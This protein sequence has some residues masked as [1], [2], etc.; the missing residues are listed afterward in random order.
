MRQI[1]LL[2][3]LG[4]LCACRSR[5]GLA[6]FERVLSPPDV[7]AALDAPDPLIVLRTQGCFGGYFA[8]VYYIEGDTLKC[9]GAEIAWYDRPDG[10]QLQGCGIAWTSTDRDIIDLYQHIVARLDAAMAHTDVMSLGKEHEELYSRFTPDPFYDYDTWVK[11]PQ[12]GFFPVSDFAEWGA[13]RLTEEIGQYSLWSLDY[14]MGPFFV[15][16]ALGREVPDDFWADRFD[17]LDRFPASLTALSDAS[18]IDHQLAALH[19]LR[20]LVEYRKVLAEVHA[21]VGVSEEAKNYDKWL[22]EMDGQ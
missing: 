4:L 12:T 6:R 17:P 15:E 9:R 19:F 8:S 14:D 1:A 10:Q 18:P 21:R 5:P 22:E 16:V 2:I 11:R 7:V 3:V 13:S 20:Y